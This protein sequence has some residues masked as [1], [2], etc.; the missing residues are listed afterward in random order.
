MA[1]TEGEWT[2]I[3]SLI[4]RMVAKGGGRRQF[5]TSQVLKRDE[6]NGVIW[7]GELGDQPI[8][9]VGFDYNVKYYGIDGSGNVTV[10]NAIA[11]P[12]TPQVGEQVLVALEMGEQSLPRCLGVVKGTNWLVIEDEV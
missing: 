6:G 2:S 5:I 1:I 7:I 3:S 10:K 11:T 8:P 9:I 4:E 12:I